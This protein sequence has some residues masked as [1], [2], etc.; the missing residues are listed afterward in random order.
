MVS[1]IYIIIMIQYIDAVR[2][3]CY[4]RREE[5]ENGC[6]YFQE[7]RREE[8]KAEKDSTYIADVVSHGR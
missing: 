4:C 2:G 1:A 3:T 5:E 6:I 8:I 7:H